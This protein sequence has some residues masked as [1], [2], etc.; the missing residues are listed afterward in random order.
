MFSVFFYRYRSCN[1]DSGRL[2]VYVINVN[3]VCDEGDSPSV[4]ETREE[5]RQLLSFSYDFCQFIF[6]VSSLLSML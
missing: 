2:F 3:S 5:A 6:I 1:S 4:V